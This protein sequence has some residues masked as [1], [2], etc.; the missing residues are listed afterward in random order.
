[1]SFFYNYIKKNNISI[2]YLL[3][4]V[5]CITLIYDW[6]LYSRMY[7][8]LAHFVNRVSKVIRTLFVIYFICNLD[9][10][11]KFLNKLLLAVIFVV[12]CFIIPV[13]RK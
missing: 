2:L 4:S 8:D 12:F 9:Y 13:Y 11:K 1:M 6:T 3:L 10:K 7:P 5:W